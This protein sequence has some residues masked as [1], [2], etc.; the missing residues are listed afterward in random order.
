MLHG[1]HP[2]LATVASAGEGPLAIV[3]V[4][5]LT[6]FRTLPHIIPS[7]SP[8]HRPLKAERFIED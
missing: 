4:A 5:F 1:M 3:R 7:L 6:G 2:I 8:E